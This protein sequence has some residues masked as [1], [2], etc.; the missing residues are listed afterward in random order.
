M[1]GLVIPW[2]SGFDLAIATFQIDELEAAYLAIQNNSIAVSGFT[3]YATEGLPPGRHTLRITINRATSDSP[4]LLDYIVFGSANYTG[5][6]TDVSST[7]LGI[8]TSTWTPPNSTSMSG[9]PPDTSTPAPTQRSIT[10]SPLTT[11]LASVQPVQSSHFPF[12]PVIGAAAGGII[13]LLACLAVLSYYCFKR[14]RR[15]NTLPGFDTA[16]KPSRLFYMV[17][18]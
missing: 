15:P 2:I 14:H 10:I 7:L 13:L 9:R 16:S 12:A 3:F 18:V 11:T 5:A 6:R 17:V 4:F 8:P 1:I